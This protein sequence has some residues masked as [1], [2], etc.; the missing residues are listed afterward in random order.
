MPLHQSVPVA[1]ATKSRVGLSLAAVVAPIED[2]DEVIMGPSTFVD[3]LQ[4]RRLSVPPM[5]QKVSWFLK[6]RSTVLTCP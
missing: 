3:M 2:E 5:R 6:P 1:K 4:A